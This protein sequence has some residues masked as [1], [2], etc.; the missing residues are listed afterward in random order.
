MDNK[1]LEELKYNVIEYKNT[2]AFDI[3]FEECDEIVALIDAAMQPPAEDV[4]RAIEF[5][6][7]TLEEDKN[8]ATPIY[9][10]VLHL[11][12]TALRQMNPEH[13]D[14]DVQRAIATLKNLKHHPND[15]TSGFGSAMVLNEPTNKVLSESIAAL[16]QMKQDNAGLDPDAD[17]YGN[18]YSR[19]YADGLRQMR[20]EPCEWCE[21]AEHCEYEVTYFEDDNRWATSRRLMPKYCPNCGRRISNENE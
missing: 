17:D 8:I 4:Q 16:R 7:E 6:E 10:K 9:L 12:I 3:C 13:T 11:T 14:P 2:R 15:H 21:L 20:T 1:R 19:G 5:W 18:G